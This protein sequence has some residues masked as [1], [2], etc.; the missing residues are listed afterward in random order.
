MYLGWKVFASCKDQ[1]IVDEAIGT[2]ADD[3][4]AW[5]RSG[6]RELVKVPERMAQLLTLAES[7]GAAAVTAALDSWGV[8][9][10]RP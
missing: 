5:N 9:W 4:V 2:D 1:A 10:F 8:P 6:W 7:E 3:L